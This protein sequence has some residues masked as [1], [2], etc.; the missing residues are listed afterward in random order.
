MRKKHT[1]N[2]DDYA[3]EME[4]KQEGAHFG[5]PLN[6]KQ[7]SGCRVPKDW[8]VPFAV[9]A[10]T[11][12]QPFNVE[13]TCAALLW[14]AASRERSERGFSAVLERFHAGLRSGLMPNTE[15]FLHRF[16]SS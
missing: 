5:W 2:P 1:A 11:E 10:R 3:G 9:V 12:K 8:V 7:S 15:P 13:L 14:C 4:Q 6:E 16:S